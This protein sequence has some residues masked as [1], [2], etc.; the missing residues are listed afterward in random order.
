MRRLGVVLLLLGVQRAQVLP[1]TIGAG[2]IE[3]QLEDQ[4]ERSPEGIDWTQLADIYSGLARN[5][6]DLNTATDVQLLKVPGMTPLLLRNLRLHQKRYGP[7]LSI[8]ELQTIPGFTEQVYRQMQP[9]IRV[10]PTAAEDLSGK[11][12]RLPSLSQLRQSSYFSFIQRAE[13]Q[14]L[15]AWNGERWVGDSLSNA[16]GGPQRLYTRL[17]L[18]AN[19]YLSVA[20][21]GEKDFFEPFRW[22]PERRYYGYDFLS[23]HIAISEIGTL[24]R[25]VL[26]DYIM[27]FGQGL[28]FARGF[29]FAKGGDPI[30]TPKQPAFGLMPYTSVNDFQFWRGAAATFS[31]LK[32]VE[33]T[34]MRSRRFLSGNPVQVI[35]DT[36]S[37]EVEVVID[38][39]LTRGQHRTQAELNQRARLRSDAMGGVLAWRKDWQTVGLTFLHQTFSPKLRLA[40]REPHRFYDFAGTATYVGSAYWDLT[41]YNLN[42]F[43]EMAMSRSQ[44]KALSAG[45]LAPLHTTVDAV[46]LLRHFDPNF[47]SFSSYTFAEAPF[48]VQNEQGFYLG[49]R[50]RPSPRWEIQ[51]FQDIYRF[52][53]YRFRISTPTHGYETL[54]QIT[55][56]VRRKFQSYIRLRHEGRPFN[57]Y[58]LYA[59][60]SEKLNDLTY[61]RRTFLRMQAVHEINPMWRFQSRLELVWYQREQR[62][63]GYLFF[64]DV[65]WQPIP[66]LSLSVRWVTYRLN[67][68]DARVFAFEAMPPT[69]FFVPFFYGYGHRTYAFLRLYL[70]EPHWTLWLRIGQNT[71]RR[72]DNMRLTRTTEALIQIEYQ[73]WGG[74]NF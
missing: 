43:G 65:R 58:W 20:V 36:I 56:T 38:R 25:L 14:S 53:W 44:G 55:Y 24:K 15:Q 21:I 5:P 57:T 46:V 34:L 28:V 32:D 39:L 22:N 6:L 74:D 52:P 2:R 47:H 51:G 3:L 63:G 54:L 60:P 35:D 41:L 1:D 26:G 13:H 40:G 11:A 9:F 59:S 72:P 37:G 70:L 33:L 12:F 69:L 10:K 31:P 67:S 68:F 71:F 66:R 7:L 30:V 17:W 16:V 8:Y 45:V 62:S 27:Q 61:H 64:Q 23:G 48:I 49:A 42:F 4:A 73:L 50:I 18:Q 19:P 29:G